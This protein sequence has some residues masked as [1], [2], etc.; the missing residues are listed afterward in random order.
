MRI[1]LD[2]CVAPLLELTSLGCWVW[3]LTQYSCLFNG[4]M[5]KL[6]PRLFYLSLSLWHVASVNYLKILSDVKQAT[7]WELLGLAE[8]ISIVFVDNSWWLNK[9]LFAWMHT[10]THSPIQSVAAADER[11]SGRPCWC[12]SRDLTCCANTG[13]SFKGS[14]PLNT[15]LLLWI[16][17][18]LTEL[19]KSN[20]NTHTH[21]CRPL[22][23][24]ETTFVNSLF[25]WLITIECRN[26]STLNLSRKVLGGTT[27]TTF[28][29]GFEAEIPCSK[30]TVTGQTKGQGQ[31]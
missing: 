3:W 26:I 17:P 1:H 2:A 27:T 7:Q 11:Q 9:K 28:F 25:F 30:I 22:W 14:A 20:W 31:S 23:Y 10:H 6:M 18:A 12:V 16:T 21:S 15:S 8:L 5:E 19:D 4:L 13:G 24:S 29:P